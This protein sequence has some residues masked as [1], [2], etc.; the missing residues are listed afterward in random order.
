MVGASGNIPSS[1]TKSKQ[2]IHNICVELI[3]RINVLEEPVN[4]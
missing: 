1:Y 3:S 4:G 2:D